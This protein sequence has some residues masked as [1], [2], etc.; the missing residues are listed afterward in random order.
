MNSGTEDTSV[1]PI[2]RLEHYRQESRYPPDSRPARNMAYD[3]D[4]IPL[5]DGDASLGAEISD[6]TG[7][8]LENGSLAIKFNVKVREP[9]RY[10]F[11]TI[12]ANSNKESVAL[13]SITRDLSAGIHPLSF[14]L[15]GIIV[16]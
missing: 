14:P 7:D 12:V 5:I 15:Y 1:D 6:F 2:I 8:A 9:G 16:R 10:S 4:Q 11:K 13:C 3:L